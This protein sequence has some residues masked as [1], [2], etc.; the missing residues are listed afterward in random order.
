MDVSHAYTLRKTGST[1][2][3]VTDNRTGCKRWDIS[4]QF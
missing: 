3:C 2:I 4:K 1:L